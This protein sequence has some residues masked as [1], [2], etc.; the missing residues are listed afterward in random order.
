MNCLDQSIIM[1]FKNKKY[2]GGGLDA[3]Q[4]KTLETQWSITF[5]ELE[6]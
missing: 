1:K 3:S 5:K 2:G 4:R 6:Q